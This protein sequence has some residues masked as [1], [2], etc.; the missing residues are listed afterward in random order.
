M[1]ERSVVLGDSVDERLLLGAASD[2]GERQND[3]R[4]ARWGRSFRRRGRCGLGLG[5]LA[6]FERIDVDRL[7][8]VLELGLAEIADLKIEPP[9][10]LPIGLF[11]ETNCARLGGAFQTCGDIDAVAHQVPVGLLDHVAEMDA[12]AQFDAAIVRHARVA[13]DH[14]VLQFDRAARRVDHAAKLDDEPVAGALDDAAMAA[15]DCWVDEVAAQRPKARQGLILVRA[16]KPAIADNV[17]D[18]DRSELSRFRQNSTPTRLPDSTG[19]TC[20]AS[21]SKPRKLI[22]FDPGGR[23]RAIAP[24]IFRDLRPRA[25][26]VGGASAAGASPAPRVR[27]RDRAPARCPSPVRTGR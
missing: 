24:T 14:A 15:R 22:G 4:E 23:R 26:A 1:R 21:L 18:Q 8:D 11:G 27:A 13:L 9:L 20:R 12:D 6:D 5:R 2:I 10:H 7:G 17:G 16:G 25:H 3:D 19:K